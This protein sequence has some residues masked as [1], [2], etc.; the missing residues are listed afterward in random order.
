M[1]SVTLVFDLDGTLA[2]TAPDLHAATNHVLVTAGR[3]TVDF[4]T[5]AALIGHGAGPMIKG[6][7]A[8]TGDAPTDDQM[9]ELNC[10]FL[11]YYRDHLTDHTELFPGVEAA[12]FRWKALGARLA[13]CTNKRHE[14]TMPVLDRL[15]ILPLFDG[16]RSADSADY[17]KPD[18]RHLI[19]AVNDAGGDLSRAVMIGDSLTDTTTA[20]NAGV[21]SIAVTFGYRNGTVESLGAD[22]IISHYDMLDRAVRELLDL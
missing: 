10:I 14:F 18:A 22:R 6:A 4:P 16:V 5:I 19:D 3:P 21:P 20:K 17:R 12:L 1:T 15:G 2:H 11:D 9:Q 13:V 7:F 8:A